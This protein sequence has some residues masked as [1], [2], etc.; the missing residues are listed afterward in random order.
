MPRAQ[1]RSGSHLPLC[2]S[3]SADPAV[4]SDA[5]EQLSTNA[6]IIMRG[7]V[8]ILRLAEAASIKIRVDSGCVMR[9]RRKG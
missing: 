1:L 8:D 5:Y 4:E 7:V 2:V 6:E 9:W 3:F